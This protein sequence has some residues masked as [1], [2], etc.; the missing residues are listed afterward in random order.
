MGKFLLPLVRDA[1][2]GSLAAAAAA[3]VAILYISS[4]QSQDQVLRDQGCLVLGASALIWAAVATHVGQ[5]GSAKS[6]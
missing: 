6:S 5:D 4:T 3:P 1:L 2:I